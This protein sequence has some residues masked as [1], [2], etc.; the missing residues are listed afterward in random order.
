VD[1]SARYTS[2]RS[3]NGSSS[4]C[5]YWAAKSQ[6]Q[7]C[8]STLRRALTAAGLPD[9]IVTRAPGYAIHVSPYEFDLHQFQQLTAEARKASADGRLADAARIYRTA[10]GLFHGEPLAGLTSQLVQAAAVQINEQMLSTVEACTDVELR[11]GRHHDL[12]GDLRRTRLGEV[13]KQV[14]AWSV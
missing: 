12:V 6:I 2:T 7:I 4:P 8:V 13:R 3:A 11:L 1:R 9:A 14:D 10:L 5:C